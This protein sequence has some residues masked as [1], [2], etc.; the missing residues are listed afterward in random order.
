[1]S[2]EK[3]RRGAGPAPKYGTKS[4]VKAVR[5]PA[6]LWEQLDT[7]ARKK[8]I[9]RNELVVQTLRRTVARNQDK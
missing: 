1:M 2:T 3:P 8:G 9:T 4:V 6:P 5:T 7:L